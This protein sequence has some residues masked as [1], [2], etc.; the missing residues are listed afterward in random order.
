MRLSKQQRFGL[1]GELWAAD[2]IESLGYNVKHLSDFFD[3]Y[4]LLIDGQLPVEVKT[5]RRR[6]RTVRPG[7]YR[8]TYWFDTSNLSQHIGDFLIVLICKDPFDASYPF[9]CP[10]WMFMGRMTVSITSHPYHY[11]GMYAE[12]LDAWEMIDQL[13]SI[14]RR[15]CQP[16]QF[17]LFSPSAMRPEI[18]I[19][20]LQTI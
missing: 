9:V 7:Y 12:Y 2:Q 5:A 4:D 18:D 14:R 17:P 19:K 20:R 15:L 10:S 6:S 11:R 8:P 13:V 16:L 1:E 3:D